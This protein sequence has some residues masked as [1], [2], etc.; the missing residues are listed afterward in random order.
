MKYPGNRLVY[1]SATKAM[2]REERKAYRKNHRYAEGKAV[3]HIGRIFYYISRRTL[4]LVQFF[5][6]AF[7]F[8][9]AFESTK[10]DLIEKLAYPSEIGRYSCLC[11]PTMPVRSDDNSYTHTHARIYWQMKK[12]KWWWCGAYEVFRNNFPF[13]LYTRLCVC[14]RL[15]SV[16]L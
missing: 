1:I 11:S 3:G 7:S 10:I 8:L 12:V 5:F 16:C 15:Y 6:L 14:V 2:Q 4:L 9:C 13:I